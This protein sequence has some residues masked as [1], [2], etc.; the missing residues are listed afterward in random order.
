MLSELSRN[1]T[2]PAQIHGPKSYQLIMTID[3]YTDVGKYSKAARRSVSIL[4]ETLKVHYTCIVLSRG[5]EEMLL[6]N[7]GSPASHIV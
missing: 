4:Q 6:V 7:S 2:L 5:N 1:A 3:N